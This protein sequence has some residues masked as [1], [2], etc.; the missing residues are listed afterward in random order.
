MGAV[1]FV[2]GVVAGLVYRRLKAEAE[3][4][5]KWWRVRSEDITMTT[6][7][8][9]L[10]SRSH[11]TMVY[12]RKPKVKSI[13]LD[14]AFML[15]MKHMRDITCQNLTRLI[16][17]CPDTNNVCI[18]TEYCSRGS[19]QDILQNESIQLDWDFK[20]SLINDI[21]EGMHYL[22]TTSIG[23]HGRLTSSRCVIDSRFV[24]KI[25][26][27]GLNF[28]NEVHAKKQHVENMYVSLP[29]LLWMAPEHLRVYPPRQISQSGDVYS[30]AI[31]LYEMCTRTEPYTAEIWY[32]SLDD[33]IRRIKRG[34]TSVR[35]T[36]KEE[37]HLPSIVN[38]TT[39]CW[40]E[41]P[42]ERPS[43]S[44]VATSFRRL[45]DRSCINVLDVLLKRMEQYANNLEGL[46]EEKTQAFIEEKK[47]SEELL[48]QVLPKSVANQLRIG[49]SV[50]PESFD[51]VTIYFSDI[52]GFT[53]ISAVST[54]FQV[55]EFLNDLYT[56]FDTIIEHYDVYK[57][58]TIGDAYMVV[59][60]I[61]ERNGT[62]HV[63]QI[64]RMSLT[65]LRSVR[66]FMIRHMPETP[67]KARIGLH[68]G[69]VCAGVVGRK[70]PRYCLFGDTVNTASRME[71]N[72]KAMKIH[73]SD[74]TKTLLKSFN[75]FVIEERGKIEVKGKGSMTTYWLVDEITRQ[76]D[77]FALQMPFTLR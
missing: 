23:V 3:I 25:T 38:L 44:N 77:G 43:F 15:E 24:L 27:F 55:V 51:S 71:S 35:P 74:E 33:T 56:C 70:M 9:F 8:S 58:E 16:G 49:K 12:V 21:V 69:P 42:T 50:N 5:S 46:V 6:Q 53:S 32:Q 61:P 20:L 47:R 28:I 14:R 66:Q 18:L 29:E 72:G 31:I 7:S 59:S 62:E 4:H 37:E 54:P 19:L 40:L 68:S 41:I 1:I 45:N 17:V 36:L 34:G 76:N 63:R 57:V 64:A 39:C 65:I 73:I 52:V 75:T 67:L 26:G 30:F 2:F 11:G 22:H 60:G 10:S 13:S 48:Y